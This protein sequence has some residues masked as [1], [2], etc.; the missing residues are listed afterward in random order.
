MKF[1]KS[2]NYFALIPAIGI[3]YL[4][5]SNNWI[6]SKSALSFLPAPTQIAF[7]QNPPYPVKFWVQKLATSTSRGENL[8][9]KVKYESDSRLPSFIDLYGN[10]VSIQY[11][12][13]DDGKYPDDIAGDGKYACLK[14]ENI[15]NLLGEINAMKS[16]ITAKG[17]VTNFNGHSGR[18]VKANELVPFD[19]TKFEN[20]GEVEIDPLLIEAELCPDAIR[21]EKS[22]FITDL[23]VVEDQSR[24]YN[25]ASGTG[26]PNG[27]WTFGTLLANMENSQHIDG[28]RGFLKNWVKQWTIDQ[29]LNG[30]LVKARKHV[31]ECLIAPWISKAQGNS[32]VAVTLENWESLWD[33]TSSNALK[34]NAPF[35]LTAIVNRIDLRGNSAYTQS[36]ENAGETRFIFSLI[37]PFTGQIAVGPDQPFS[38]QQNGIGFGDWRGLNVILEFGNVQ[39]SKCE[40]LAL[41]QQWFDLSDNSYS[42]GNA[43]TDNP[44]KI[45]LQQIT[46]YVTTSNSKPGKINNSAINR[47][48]TNEK[49]LGNRDL[50]LETHLGWARMDWEFRQYELD[51]T[52]HGFKM[53][54][55][56][57]TPPVVS[58]AASNIDEDFSGTS[59]VVINDNLLNWIYSGNKTKVRHGNYNMPS[60]LLAS[61]SIVT[62]EAA[63]YFDF[64]RDN[65]VLNSP[66]YNASIASEE[67]K[68]IRQ[69]FSLNTCIGCHNG[70]SKT[71]FTHVNPL[72]YNESARYW[73]PTL[74]GNSVVQDRG[75]YP[76]G[77]SLNEIGGYNMGNTDDSN[78]G[79]FG[80]YS[81]DDEFDA[82]NLFQS[83]SPFLTGRRFRSFDAGSG[84]AST[85]QDDERDDTNSF[86]FYYELNDTSLDGLFYVADP[87]NGG[88]FP[89][90]DDKKWGY[91]DLLRRK[92]GLCAFLINGCSGVVGQVNNLS[93]MSLMRSISFISLPLAGH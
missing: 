89:Y 32:N 54:P 90:I 47:I 30:Q 19:Q 82:Q 55:L 44:Y 1:M 69:Q 23:A 21:L 40:V 52:T 88:L 45:A 34:Q 15:P 86:P 68:E 73:L 7:E 61:S 9:F 59:Q 85:W 3:T 66:N 78:F 35:K 64:N 93:S 11:T 83:I 20:N 77:I 10:S 75:S 28:V 12:L 80:N 72:A 43:A 71:R 14:K 33:A 58:N 79:T 26:N 39:A 36:L 4:L 67:A 5:M 27:A 16:K 38:Q 50:S 46:D 37:D 42:F 87:S 74:D 57:N 53:V 41:A 29:S 56:T 25:V 24:T 70:E 49:A 76:Y 60:Y 91:N 2:L 22:L 51:P 18:I 13:R 6:G 63:H 62:S 84:K 65:W 48:R 8:I 81:V 92:N 17:Y 31:L